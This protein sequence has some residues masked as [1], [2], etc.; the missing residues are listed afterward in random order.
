MLKRWNSVLPQIYTDNCALQGFA[1]VW[2]TY[3]SKF[4][5]PPWCMQH[6]NTICWMHSEIIW[7]QAY[8][9]TQAYV[10][11]RITRG[12]WNLDAWFF[13]ISAFS[14]NHKY[15]NFLCMPLFSYYIKKMY[16]IG[17][18]D[19]SYGT[20]LPSCRR[21]STRPILS[22]HL[23]SL[24][25]APIMPPSPL[26]SFLAHTGWNC[27]SLVPRAPACNLPAIK[28]RYRY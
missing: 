15:L 26:H 2:S 11:D 22:T 12:S 4:L 24:L 5:S 23:S 1:A 16:P 7:E 9:L 20:H 18:G 13:L 10:Q 3:R 28:I 25:N 21:P 14:P 8:D 6:H 19:P 17:D 27:T